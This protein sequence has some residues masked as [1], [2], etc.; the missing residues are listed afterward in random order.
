MEILKIAILEFC[1]KNKNKAFD[2]TEVLKIIYPQ[3]W[4]QFQEDLRLAAYQL[5]QN[6]KILIF[7]NHILVEEIDMLDDEFQIQL[8]SNQLPKMKF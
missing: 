7:K 3:D 5:K 1:R 6:K 8:N 2:A 4:E